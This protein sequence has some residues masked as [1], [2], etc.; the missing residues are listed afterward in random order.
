MSWWE[1]LLVSFGLYVATGLITGGMWSYAMGVKDADR[2]DGARLFDYVELGIAIV[3]WPLYIVIEWG[4]EVYEMIY[5]FG[6]GRKFRQL[7]RQ[8]KRAQTKAFKEL[9]KQ[10]GWNYRKMRGA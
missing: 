3:L 2:D 5:R 10:N 7:K 9:C 8:G 4:P 1:W 6:R